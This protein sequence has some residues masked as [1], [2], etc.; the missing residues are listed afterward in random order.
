MK[1]ACLVAST[2]FAL[3]VLASVS[4]LWL[5]RIGESILGVSNPVWQSLI[6]ACGADTVDQKL[7]LAFGVSLVAGIVAIGGLTAY[8]YRRWRHS[9]GSDFEFY[10]LLLAFN[11]AAVLLLANALWWFGYAWHF[12]DASHPSW[13]WLK[14]TYGVDRAYR[15]LDWAFPATSVVMLVAAAGTARCAIARHRRSLA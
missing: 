2:A 1:K 10:A 11:G 8:G 6:Q 12:I 9:K 4:A 3:L 13:T 14:E 15:V 5:E 7:D